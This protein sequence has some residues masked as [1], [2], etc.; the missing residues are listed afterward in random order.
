MRLFSP[1][2]YTALCGILLAVA[3]LAPCPA[4]AWGGVLLPSQNDDNTSTLPNLGLGGSASSPTPATQA[5]PA[6]PATSP[7]AP[8]AAAPSAGELSTPVPSTATTTFD[9]SKIATPSVTSPVSKSAAAHLA[10]GKLPTTIIHEADVSA[11]LA[12]QSASLPDSLTISIGGQSFFGAKDV[13]TIHDKLGLSQNQVATSCILTV[14]GI[15]Q[16]SKGAAII[17]GGNAAQVAV[18]YDGTIK[19]YFMSA[20]ALCT[21]GH[22]PDDAGFLTEIGGRYDITL[23]AISCPAPTRQTQQLVITYDGTATSRCDYQ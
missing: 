14:R 5:P 3:T 12:A 22:L 17:N 2:R 1:L 21:A 6:A 4:W 11:M 13:E 18:R 23:Q 16:T 20:T 10:P 15:V 19:G 8:P 9:L 7:A